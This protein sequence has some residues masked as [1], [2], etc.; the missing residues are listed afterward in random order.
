MALCNWQYII[1]IHIF[2]SWENT[3]NF[4]KC[5]ISVPFKVSQAR[6]EKIEMLFLKMFA[7]LPSYP[8]QA[9]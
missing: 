7:Q 6:G 5:K 3:T 8:V 4:D 2:E 9:I 1:L